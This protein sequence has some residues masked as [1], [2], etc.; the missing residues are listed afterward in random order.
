MVKGNCLTRYDR[1]ASSPTGVCLNFS[2][3][4]SAVVGDDA[5]LRRS[6]ALLPSCT[7]VVVVA[8]VPCSAA[9]PSRALGCGDFVLS[10]AAP[11]AAAAANTIDFAGTKPVKPAAFPLPPP[12]IK[13]PSPLTQLL[14]P[15]ATAA[16]L[17][18]A[19]FRS[20]RTS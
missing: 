8:P 14:F 1:S 5:P 15:V 19:R 20:D 18:A 12:S 16:A 4:S 10:T 7:V 9:V 6:V 13:L 11:G 17:T 2:R 3:T